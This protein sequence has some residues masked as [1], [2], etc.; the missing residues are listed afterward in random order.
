MAETSLSQ[1]QN[2]VD[3]LTPLDQV[4]LMEYISSQIEHVLSS[5]APVS[6]EDIIPPEKAWAHFFDVGLELL[7]SDVQKSDTLTSTLLAMRR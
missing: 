6:D 1:I 3:S 2:L 7:K 4:K 5:T